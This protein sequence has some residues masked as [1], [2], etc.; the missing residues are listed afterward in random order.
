M[1]VLLIL[2]YFKYTF[3][4]LYLPVKSLLQHRELFLSLYKREFVT[5]TRGSSLGVFWLIGQQALQVVAL[6]FLID[7][8]LQ[9][10]FPGE[11]PFLNYFLAGMIPW[12]MINEILSR[13]TG[14]YQEYG[15]LFKRTIFPLELLPLV[16]IAFSLSTFLVVYLL[17]ILLLNG[18]LSM[19][20]AIFVFFLLA[21]WLLP[22]VY[23][24]SILGVFIN[25]FSK[26]VPFALT[27]IMYLSPILYVPQ[28]IP[29]QY[30]MYLILNPVADLMNFIH[31]LVLQ[32][33]W[34]DMGTNLRLLLQ[35]LLVSGPAWML[36]K[37]AQKHIRDV[38]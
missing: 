11:T 37:R 8:I 16:S 3:L 2:N 21:L 7:V 25:D 34:P 26:I 24:F 13:A 23:L 30:Q 31:L 9:V 15:A 29:E 35:W 33:Q 17:V 18:W 4:S 5:K 32:H 1:R 38:I 19:L 36:F 20:I 6:W 14:L 22:M 12:L 27:M 10:R 28:M